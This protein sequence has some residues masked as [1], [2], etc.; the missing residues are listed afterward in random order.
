MD[1]SG[2][3]S[4]SVI[5]VGKVG[6]PIAVMSANARIRTIGV[7]KDSQRIRNLSSAD[8]RLLR[9]EE[10]LLEAF[11]SIEP[12]FLTFSTD[13]REAVGSTNTTVVSVPLKLTG[14]SKPDFEDLDAVFNAIFSVAPPEHL[15]ILETTVPV[16]TTRGR[17]LKLWREYLQDYEALPALVFSP[18]RIFV[19]RTLTTLRQVPKLLGAVTPEA[20]VRAKEFFESVIQFEKSEWSGKQ[21]GAWILSSPESAEFAKL[22]ETT[23][24]DV[25]IAL[26][27]EFARYAL[28]ID[29]DFT[30][31]LT[32]C[33]SQ[34][35]SHIHS[36][37]IWVGGHCIPVYPELYLSTAPP[38]NQSLVRT[39]RDIN[40]SIHE[41][42]LD[43]LEH[44]VPL[45]GETVLILG[46]SYRAGVK[47]TYLSGAFAIADA[48]ERRGA[49]V[50]VTDPG[51]SDDELRRLGFEPLNNRREITILI[52]QT[53]EPCFINLS[54]DK[55]PNLK[56]VVDGRS[57]WDS[58]MWPGKV[59]VG[60][61]TPTREY[62]PE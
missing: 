45:R 22:A 29:V 57:I 26:A 11:S 44:D 40:K 39:A 30:E 32:A 6:L 42:L 46:A 43:R 36:P 20:A 55:F 24:R 54:L 21:N 60:F 27:N 8:S 47:E 51:Y 58:R 19:G 33:N 25:N 9:N 23:Y 59:F 13:I 14:D 28:S 5:G 52:S 35:F 3:F 48:C 4:L 49:R 31:V 50:V 37:G 34:P 41:S 12:G 62:S 2:Q 53:S 61:G 16:G 17:Y 38:V 56:G 1:F 18:E 15:V 10:G 7:D